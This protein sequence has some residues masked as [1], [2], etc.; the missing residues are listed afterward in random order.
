MFSLVT[1]IKAQTQRDTLK[2]YMSQIQEYPDWTPFRE[3]IINLVRRMK[4][5]P[6]VPD[7][8]S[9]LKG[10]GARLFSQAQNKDDFKAV[11]DVFKQ[12]SLI[13]PWKAEIYYNL[14]L[15]EEKA[16]MGDHAIANYRLYM[17]ADPTANHDEVLAR[18]GEVQA[19]QEKAKKDKK[20]EKTQEE[21]FK[22][23]MEQQSFQ[24]DMEKAKSLYQGKV[25]K[26]KYCT[27]PWADC[28]FKDYIYPHKYPCGCT[29]NEMNGEFWYSGAKAT[30]DFNE[31]GTIS[32]NIYF[33]NDQWGM[34]GE[35]KGNKINWYA[36]DGHL[37]WTKGFLDGWFY[38]SIEG[39]HAGRPLNDSDVR[40]NDIYMYELI[41]N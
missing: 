26:I 19:D 41:Y 37:V 14:A 16:E 24:K 13:A 31:N 39:M 5:K 8:Y 9:I 11:V 6:V 22:H 33:L 32:V 12:A 34:Y 27:K 4:V 2:V 21:E 17:L 15:A 18:I 29:L 7:D 3:N 36:Q 10:K 38:F 30:I 40:S 23:L 20:E 25:L 1:I 28:M 35:P